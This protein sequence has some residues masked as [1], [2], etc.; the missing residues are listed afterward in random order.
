LQFPSGMAALADYVHS[1]GLKLGLY[2]CVG[3]ETCKKKRPG[4]YGRPQ[5]ASNIYFE[6]CKRTS[7][8][9]QITQEMVAK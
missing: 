7:A 2:T 4:S 9:I 1:K 5:S 6:Q 8:M 3:T